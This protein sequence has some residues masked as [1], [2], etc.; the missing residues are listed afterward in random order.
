LDGD[1]VV[2]WLGD[3]S[4]RRRDPPAEVWQY[5][6]DKCVLDLFLYDEDDIQ[7]VARAEIRS[8]TAGEGNGCL[9]HMLAARH[10]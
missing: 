10:G 8:R 2:A 3:P 5:Y 6:G 1:A 4:F 7:R 9:V